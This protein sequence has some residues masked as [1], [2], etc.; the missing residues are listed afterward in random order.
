MLTENKVRFLLTGILLAAMISLS[1]CTQ[2][3]TEQLYENLEQDKKM[4]RSEIQSV[5]EKTDSRLKDLRARADTLSAEKARDIQVQIDKLEESKNELR[6]ELGR[7]SEATRD[8]WEDIKRNARETALEIEREFS[9][10][11]AVDYER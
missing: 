10:E 1:A 6:E 7:I 5:M 9:E 11:D 2:D 4:V 3:K 8:S